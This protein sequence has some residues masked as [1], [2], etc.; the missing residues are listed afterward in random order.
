ME[1][2]TSRRQF[3]NL[4]FPRHLHPRK[5]GSVDDD[6]NGTHLGMDIA[7]DVANTCTAELHAFRGSGFVQTEIKWFAVV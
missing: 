5:M 6:H 3:G 2:I 4:E 7:K 1:L